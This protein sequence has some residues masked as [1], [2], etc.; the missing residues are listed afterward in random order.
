ME[1]LRVDKVLTPPRLQP[2]SPP[3]PPQAP[4]LSSVAVTHHVV[5]TFKVNAACTPALESNI[6]N[7]MAEHSGVAIN[8]TNVTCA[9]VPSTRRRR[10]DSAEVTVTLG[11]TAEN[12]GAVQTAAQ[13]FLESDA[14]TTG[15]AFGASVSEPSVSQSA[16]STAIGGGAK[17]D[18]HLHF[19]HGGTAD[20]RGRDG[21]YYNFFSAPGISLNVRTEDATFMLH[22]GKLTV[23]G[24]FITE[25]HLVAG[26]G[27]CPAEAPRGRCAGIYKKWLNV[28]YLASELTEQNA[29]FTY[30][31]GTCGSLKP[32]EGGIAFRRLCEDALVQSRFSSANFSARGWTFVLRG[33]ATTKVSPVLAG[34]PP[35][36]Q[37]L[38]CI[39]NHVY[40]RVSG[41]RHRLDVS[42]SAAEGTAARALPHGIVGQTFSSTSPRFGAKDWYPER[43]HFKTAAQA[44]GAI[45]GSVSMYE[46]ASPYDTRF[47]FSRFDAQMRSFHLR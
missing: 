2:P 15:T 17:Q 40:E 27:A 28:S 41:P 23:D 43:G 13:S 21:A 3:M 33:D 46:V 39:G 32:F 22:G 5:A 9:T 42:I 47:A 25:A 38:F 1:K 7:Q 26:A 35:R 6:R 31:R 16:V 34:S 10:L 12:A 20:L 30:L 18:P 44:Q 45:E 19:A 4:A 36:V 37:R 24:S 11:T 29:G 8:N 14:A